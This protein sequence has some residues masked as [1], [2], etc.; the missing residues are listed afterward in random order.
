MRNA[1]DL[2]VRAFT[3]VAGLAVV[4]A[5]WE[6]L[7]ALGS[8]PVSVARPT[9]ILDEL[10]ERSDTLWFHTEPTL[11]SA[12]WGFAWATAASFL[13]AV[14]I[15][16][17]PRTAGS[18]YNTAVIVSSVPLIALTPVLVLWLERG[19]A[20]RITIAAI[21]GFFPILVGCIQ[22]L[23]RVDAQTDELFHQLAANRRQRFL[24]LS[25]PRSLPFVFAGLKAAAAAAVLGAV[26]AEWTGGGGTRGLGQMMTNALFGFNVPLTWLTILTTAALSIVAYAAIALVERLVVRWDVDP[27]EVSV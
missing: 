22:G 20:V 1:G 2:A 23:G 13:V 19:P 15:V 3:S 18:L 10:T 11:T 17:V 5:V 7:G 8:L 9:E 14:V 27:S 16:F 21:A 24:R 12:A 26:I 4:V 6:L 25:L